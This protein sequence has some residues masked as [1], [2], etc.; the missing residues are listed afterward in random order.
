MRPRPMTCFVISTMTASLAALR[1]AS[2]GT[3]REAPA[4]V[5]PVVTPVPYA[6]LIGGS[7][8]AAQAGSGASGGALLGVEGAWATTL[9]VGDDSAHGAW[10]F[11]A[12]AGWAFA[13]GLA[14]HIRY[15]DLGV[16]PAH[17]SMPLQ[18]ATVGLR[19][20]IPFLVPLP[21]A[22]VDAGPAFVAGDV[23]FGAGAGAGVSVP[24]G[25]QVLVDVSG[26]DWLVPIAGLL[27][28]TITVG[29]GLAVSFASPAR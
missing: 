12:R 20:S 23:R 11:G 9:G 22:E 24:L 2:A 15:D 7:P 19:Y 5:L 1:P 8:G 17:L 14:V 26:R 21:F 10:A 18:L 3:T 27:R 13:N 4:L 16:E 29:L 28:Q 25:R 6:R